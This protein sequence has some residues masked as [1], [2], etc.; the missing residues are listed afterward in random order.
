[1]R[2]VL[3][4][5]IA[6]LLSSH[7][8]IILGIAD[9]DYSDAISTAIANL[10]KMTYSALSKDGDDPV[11]Q[12]QFVDM[13]NGVIKRTGDDWIVYDKL[14]LDSQKE[15]IKLMKDAGFFDFMSLLLNHDYMAMKWHASFLIHTMLIG[16]VDNE[17]VAEFNRLLVDVLFDKGIVTRL[18]KLGLSED[19]NEIEPFYPGPKSEGAPLVNAKDEALE[20][21]VNIVY[22]ARPGKLIHKLV[23][24]GAR[25]AVCLAARRSSE[26]KIFLALERVLLGLVFNCKMMV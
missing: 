5:F 25:D 19:M 22:Y 14:S 10:P 17:S 2:V 15:Y 3:L 6:T 26:T 13:I 20:A 12:A 21:V 7:C 9:K 23:D 1:M 24:S 16:G 11:I 8:G 4:S 18:I